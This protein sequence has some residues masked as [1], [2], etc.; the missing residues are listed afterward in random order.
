MITLKFA[1]PAKVPHVVNGQML[2]MKSLISD[3]HLQVALE[4]HLLPTLQR[5]F[6]DAEIQIAVGAANKNIVQGYM[7]QKEKDAKAL[8]RRLLEDMMA[9]FSPLAED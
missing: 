8:V 6:P 7:G 4:K 9:D 1:R 5:N 2:G 3:E